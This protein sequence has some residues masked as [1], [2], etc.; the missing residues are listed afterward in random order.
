MSI[1]EQL[2][3]EQQQEILADDAKKLELP[4]KDDCPIAEEEGGCINCS[5]CGYR[6]EYNQNV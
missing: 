6:D 2:G 1:E 4:P 3:P 5:Y